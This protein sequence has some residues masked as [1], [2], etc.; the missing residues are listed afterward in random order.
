MQS[1][2]HFHCHQKCEQ[3]SRHWDFVLDKSVVRIRELLPKW[4]DDRATWQ[5]GFFVRGTIHC[6]CCQPSSETLLNLILPAAS[7][8]VH[9]SLADKEFPWRPWVY[10]FRLTFSSRAISHRGASTQPRKGL[11]RAH[12]ERVWRMPSCARNHASHIWDFRR[13]N[14]CS[15]CEGRDCYSWEIAP[16]VNTVFYN[17]SCYLSCRLNKFRRFCRHLVEWVFRFLEKRLTSLTNCTSFAPSP[18]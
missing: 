9:V 13:D 15:F 2:I 4:P 6:N 10:R 1:V 7:P 3:Y 18:N 17:K 12:V 11:F 8:H 14:S 5:L 16:V